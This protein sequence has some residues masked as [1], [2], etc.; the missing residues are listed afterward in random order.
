VPGAGEIYRRSEDR[1]GF[2]V[3]TSDGTTVATDS[4]QGHAEKAQAQETLEKLLRGEF[5]GPVS[6]ATPA[7]CGDEIT[8]DTTLDGDLDC[9]NGPG[10]VI[11]ADNV[12]LDLG[13]HRVSGAPDGS[14]GPGILLQNVSGVTVKNGV[15]ER[16]DAGV[17]IDGGGGNVV[18]NLVVR[19]N[20]GSAEGDYGDG[21]VVYNS[22]GNRIEK[23]TVER[24]GPYSG[25][26]LGE[27]AQGNE[28]RD[29]VVADNNMMHTGNA[30]AGRM[31]MG[32]RIEGPGANDNKVAGN[33]VSGS[34]ASGIALLATCVNDADCRGTA[35]NERNEL[36]G[37]RT[38]RNG[39]SGRGVGVEVF[40]LPNPVTPVLNTISGNVADENKTFGIAIGALGVNNEGDTTNTA[41]GNSAHNNGQFD[42]FDGNASPACGTNVWEGNDFGTVNQP[43]VRGPEATPMMARRLS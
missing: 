8:Q 20:I 19:D 37:N 10:L 30:S 15:V 26:A 18:Q 29:N 6:E 12:T 42:G 35:A 27:Q 14:G 28:V 33:T 4:G 38:S 13:G 40:S 17:V 22:S 36:S 43:C 32:I 34:G 7:A 1:W 24:N 39:T 31:D 2:R 11:A 9:E 5:D 23:N 3:K 21:I 41:R 16:F 25:I